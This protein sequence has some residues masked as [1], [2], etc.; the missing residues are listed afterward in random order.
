MNENRRKNKRRR[1][2]E[3]LIQTLETL[4]DIDRMARGEKV[5]YTEGY[6][7]LVG[8]IGQVGRRLEDHSL[9]E[10]LCSTI[11]S[12]ASNIDRLSKKGRPLRQVKI[13]KVSGRNGARVRTYTSVEGW[14]ADEPRVGENYLIYT[15][16]ACIFRSSQV[17]DVKKDYFQTQNSLYH[18]EFLQ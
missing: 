1:G 8:A 11:E 4:Q 10:M 13:T 17:I 9:G 2:D 14:E 7:N 15:Y 6:T 16:D 18:I 5:D 12:I 3:F